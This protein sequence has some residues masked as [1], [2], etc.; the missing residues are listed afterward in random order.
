LGTGD[1]VDAGLALARLALTGS[2]WLLFACTLGAFF[3]K[4]FA[5]LALRLTAT[6]ATLLS[7]FAAFSRIGEGPG[8][9][10]LGRTLA[11][12]SLSAL[13]LLSAIVLLALAC[14]LACASPLAP[15]SLTRS[16]GGCAVRSC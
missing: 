15:A 14:R 8:A 2:A 3:G 16:G 13:L 7:G 10:S 11:L 6:A 5:A 1:G 9:C 12:R 4:A